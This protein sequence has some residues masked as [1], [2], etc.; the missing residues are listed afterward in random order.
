MKVCKVG[1]KGRKGRKEDRKGREGLDNLGGL[2]VQKR[3]AGNRAGAEENQLSP[4]RRGKMF[5]VGKSIVKVI[6]ENLVTIY[7]AL[8]GRRETIE[9]FLPILC[10]YAAA[11]RAPFLILSTSRPLRLLRALCV[12]KAKRVNTKST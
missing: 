9:G 3:R 5:W 10:S 4:P 11:F 2:C 1:E 12:Q 7:F 8:T 6:T